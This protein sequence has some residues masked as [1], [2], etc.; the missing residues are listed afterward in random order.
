MP[1]KRDTRHV[2]EYSKASPVSAVS[3]T[4][5]CRRAGTQSVMPLHSAR[6]VD[7][8]V[9][10]HEHFSMQAAVSQWQHR[11]AAIRPRQ[12]VASVA[13]AAAE[14]A[15]ATVADAAAVAATAAATAA[16]VL[17][18]GC[19]DYDYPHTATHTDAVHT[20]THHTWSVT[21]QT[22]AVQFAALRFCCLINQRKFF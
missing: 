13:V 4:T 22:L 15:A 10:D 18:L 3:C 14:G 1:I 19:S 17:P 21:G 9:A 11:S 12:R 16:V 6:V 8:D 20:D 7:N 2:H 5:Q